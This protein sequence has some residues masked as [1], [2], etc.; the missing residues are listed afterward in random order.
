MTIE[1][2]FYPWRMEDK[3]VI[4]SLK[5]SENGLNEDEA[6]KRLKIYGKNEIKSIKR[7]WFQILLSQFLSPFII[8][9]IGATILS[10][11]V[12]DKIDALVIFGII[13]INGFLGF[14]QEY[15]SEKT[16]ASLKKYISYTAKVKREGII[17]E[18]NSTNLVPGDIVILETGDRVPADLRI[19]KA[20]NFA[21]DESILTGESY[22]VN[23]VS[24]VLN[25][26]K[27][28]IHEI[29][30]MTFM[31]TFVSEGICEGI[32]VY[33]GNK[34]KFGETTELVKLTE[35]HGS[36]HKNL[37]KFSN[38]LVKIV[39]V[40][41][42]TIFLINAFLNKG[43]LDSFIFAIAI[44]VGMVPESLPIVITISLSHGAMILAKNKVVVKKLA[45]IEDLGNIDVLCTDK[46]GTLTENNIS[47]SDF[48]NVD[49]KQDKEV[50]LYGYLCN[51][52]KSSKEK[53]GNPLDIAIK[54]VSDKLISNQ[55]NNFIQRDVIPFDFKTRKMSVLVESK[56]DKLI[57]S[58]GA[59]EEIFS[60]CS[61]VKLD[62]KVV[63]LDKKRKEMIFNKF[64]SFA[65]KGF[66]VLAV[67][68]KKTKLNKI[69]KEADKEM[70]LCG[71]LIFIDPPKKGVKEYLQQ[72]EKL[73]VNIKIITGDEPIVAKQIAEQVGLIVKSE[74]IIIGDELDKLNHNEA[75]KIVNRTIIFA[76]VNPEQKYKIINYLK[77][78]GHVVAYLGDG[79]NDAPALKAADVGIAVNNGADVAKEVSDIILLEKGINI[80][81][82]GVI[83]GRR[84][85]SN[86]T[87]YIL[88]T[89]SANFGNIGTMSFISP[90]LKFI[91]LLPSQILLN[92]LL[93]DTP[94][95]SISSDNVE[96]SD[97]KKPRHWN[98]KKVVNSS[99]ILGAISSF[100]DLLT[101]F[102]LL[103]LLNV[104]VPLFRTAWFLE[105]GLSELLIAFSIRSN[106]SIFKSKKPSK[107][108]LIFSIGTIILTLLSIYTPIRDL[109]QFV[110]LPLPILIIIV[111]I[112][113]G[114]IF[115]VEIIKKFINFYG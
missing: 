35:E 13:L 73:G 77:E 53:Y 14:I 109:F 20:S 79:I 36:F 8:I 100:F 76:R 89:I 32:V 3:D 69:G 66:K 42:A 107:I 1:N 113:L 102:S 65:E 56:K 17:K 68:Y 80:I 15:K 48:V 11:I 12:G 5:S 92:N 52:V 110:I 23:K 82:R 78:A 101:I 41:V 70:V 60:S 6:E 91:P 30:N 58:K 21:V 99:I 104:S 64:R 55:V 84:T 86:M 24:S 67:S 96:D 72:T 112:L 10:F 7:Q 106:K 39:L 98:I 26:E 22:P 18:I 38:T 111:G 105:S 16:M 31:G 63:A 90:F 47:L 28:N 4:L 37:T 40:I 49:L 75:I 9:L 44:A 81:N 83:E 29:N 115:V 2:K 43:W 57:I 34:T 94:M 45:A 27:P 59:F 46:T 108:F 93:T 62:N 51:S 114:Y 19:L 25:I 71:F 85:F 61:K 95:I 74:E 50:L 88:N 54:K 97:L 33:T 87:K 103:F